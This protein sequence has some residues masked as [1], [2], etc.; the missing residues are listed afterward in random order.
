[1][2][3]YKDVTIASITILKVLRIMLTIMFSMV[4][5]ILD[6]GKKITQLVREQVRCCIQDKRIG[7]PDVST[8]SGRATPYGDIAV[9]EHCLSDNLSH[10][11][12]SLMR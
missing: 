4:S 11:G 12:L 2:I 9:G 1:M 7:I 10:C 8:H 5:N 6:P 3:D